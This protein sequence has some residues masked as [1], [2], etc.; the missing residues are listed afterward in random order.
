MRRGRR[1]GID[2]GSVRVGIAYSDPDGI[3]ASPLEVVSRRYGDNLALMRIQE[4]VDELDPVE[5]VIGDPT[6]LDGK[7]RAS[8]AKAREFADKIIA[9][10]GVSARFVDERFT[11]T[12]AH[13]LL[14][15]VGKTS[16]QRRETVDAQAAVVILQTALDALAHEAKDSSEY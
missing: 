8:A 6:S 7:D 13:M 11:T 14:Q 2:V 10:T 4:I 16:K 5:L 12:Q 9:R 15:S 1:V 3:L